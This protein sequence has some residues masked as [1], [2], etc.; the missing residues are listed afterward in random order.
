MKSTTP[1]LSGIKQQP[2]LDALGS[3]G[4]ELGPG[5]ARVAAHDHVAELLNC[6]TLP[7]LHVR[8]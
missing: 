4:Q 7:I 5:T 3:M 6:L 1:K 8:Q 2:F